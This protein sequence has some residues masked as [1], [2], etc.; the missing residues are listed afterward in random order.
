[1]GFVAEAE[2][3]VV[4]WLSSRCLLGGGRTS[5]HVKHFAGACLVQLQ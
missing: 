4:R 2:R 1:M 3:F 5:R